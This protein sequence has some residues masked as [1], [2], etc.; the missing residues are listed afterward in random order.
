MYDADQGKST[1]GSDAGRTM[2]G[3][4]R[5]SAQARNWRHSAAGL[6][7]R[8]SSTCEKRR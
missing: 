6:K 8:F 4:A 3:F 5:K 7:K 2:A 1:P